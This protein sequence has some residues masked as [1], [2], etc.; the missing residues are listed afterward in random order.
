MGLDSC[1]GLRGCCRSW[2]GRARY[3]ALLTE[4]FLVQLGQEMPRKRLTAGA[5]AKL[6]EYNWPGNVREL[7]HVLE[8]GAILCGDR[9]EIGMDEIR[10]RRVT[11]A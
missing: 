11:R 3:I 2:W 9:Q 8:R 6:H 1:S 10:F 5:A 7:M 4:H